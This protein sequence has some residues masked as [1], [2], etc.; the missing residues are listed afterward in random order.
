MDGRSFAHPLLEPTKVF[1]FVMQD[2]EPAALDDASFEPDRRLR[3]QDA[4]QD[5]RT[6]DAIAFTYRTG[7]GTLTEQMERARHAPGPCGW[8][9]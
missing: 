6:R 3:D 2:A 9:P 1:S 4:V 7:R 8:P 5:H